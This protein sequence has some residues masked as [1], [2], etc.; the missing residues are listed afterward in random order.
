MA[1]TKTDDPRV[2]KTRRVLREALIRLILK[3]GYQ[4]IS[5]QDIADEAETARITFYRH[6]RDKEELLTDCLNVVY[7]E[8]VERTEREIAGGG[9]LST[10][11]V[12]VFFEH[13]EEQEPL[14]LVLFSSLG[15]HT[16]LERMKRLMAGHLLERMPR[17]VGLD[18]PAIPDEI[19]ANYLVS[20]QLGI[21]IWWLEN[22]KPYSV[23]YMVRVTV[24]L[25]FA[26]LQRALGLE[27]MPLTSPAPDQ[28]EL[29]GRTT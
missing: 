26:G 17:R 2:R 27:G 14:Y 1:V 4:S 5:I 9:D 11:P 12:R 7:D 18:R 15:T 10:V 24:W 16:V 21:G 6:Y 22:G 13:L 23:D 28:P 25:G 3:C 20:A 29:H 19:I 8:L